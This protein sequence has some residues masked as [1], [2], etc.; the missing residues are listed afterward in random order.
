[1][2]NQKPI[3]E[4]TQKALE[5]TVLLVAKDAKNTPISQGSGFV[6]Q[7]TQIV[8]NFHVVER[9]AKVE[10]KLI[11][12]DTLFNIKGIVAI[13]H[14]NDLVLL[15][16]FNDFEAPPLELAD[17]DIVQ[18]SDP[19]YVVG[20]P[21]G[22]LEGTVSQGII[23]G[24][25]ERHIGDRHIQMTAP[26]SEG[27]SGGPVLNNE[28]AV[29]GISVGSIVQGQLLNFAIPSNC[30]KALL[31]KER[32][33]N[34]LLEAVTIGKLTWKRSGTYHWI[35]RI[36]P[37]H[38][39]FSLERFP[40]RTNDI[41]LDDPWNIE[42]SYRFSL[43]NQCLEDIE[44]IR[45]YVTFFDTS[46]R[47]VYRDDV[48]FPG[49]LPAGAAK[50]I[51]FDV[52]ASARISNRPAIEIISFDRVKH[53]EP[54]NSN[55]Q[56]LEG[57]TQFGGWKWTKATAFGFSL[58]KRRRE[59]FKDIHCQIKFIDENDK[60]IR[61]DNISS[62]YLSAGLEEKLINFDIDP[63]I[64]Q[65]RVKEDIKLLHPENDQNLVGEGIIYKNTRWSEYALYTFSLRNELDKAVK[66]IHCHIFFFSEQIDSDV[67]KHIPID[68]DVVFFDGSIPSKMTKQ[69]NGTIDLSIAEQTEHFHVKIIN[70]DTIE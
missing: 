40:T 67:V 24:F 55:S 23:S 58:Q 57:V 3:R 46:D 50:L 34:P 2:N 12:Q 19:L 32:A 37:N 15:D 25:R 49:I 65:L 5:S 18:I 52:D 7:D 20:N 31:T 26:I 14:E 28:G 27:S 63:N 53:S 48:I 62:G 41:P 54:N 9:A 43:R 45:C 69:V 30:L 13:D 56:I 11:G 35:S 22:F 64:R 66:N 6:V 38:G 70:F 42:H 29:V 21:Q 61:I 4:I 1:M 10:V 36:D 59:A 33:P 60:Q 51:N 39:S 8:S 47:K 16:V 17:S 44:N 68:S